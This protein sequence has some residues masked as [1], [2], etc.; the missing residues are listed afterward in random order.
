MRVTTKTQRLD[1]AI[2]PFEAYDDQSAPLV[3]VAPVAPVAREGRITL[4]I[5]LSAGELFRAASVVGRVVLAL[6]LAAMAV[7]VFLLVVVV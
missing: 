3:P 1:T 7:G 4:A 5:D 6:L 2:V